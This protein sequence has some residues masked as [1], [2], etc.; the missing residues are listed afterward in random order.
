MKFNKIEDALKY[1][2][3]TTDLYLSGEECKK[4]YTPEIEKLTNLRSLHYFPKTESSILF[5]QRFKKLELES[6]HI[7]SVRVS[8]LMGMKIK[9]LEIQISPDEIL[10]LCNNFPE[11]E[12]LTL[13]VGTEFS[14]PKE[15]ENLTNLRSLSIRKGTLT[16]VPKTIGNLKKLKHLCL[17]SLNLKTLPLEFTEIPN[18]EEFS[19]RDSPQLMTLPKEIENWQNLKKITL[20]DLFKKKEKMNFEN[21][22]FR[23]EKGTELPPAL[24]GL[25]HLEEFKLMYCPVANLAPLAS[26][27]KLKRIKV[28]QAELND[29]RGVKELTNLES[30]ELGNSYHVNSIESLSELTNLKSLD[31]SDMKIKN[32]NPLKKLTRLEFLN[33][34]NCSFD[35][36]KSKV[37]QALLPLYAFEH[38]TEVEATNITL[39][40]WETRDKNDAQK[41]CLNSEDI[42]TILKDKEKSLRELED[43]LNSIVE[44]ESLFR[45]NRYDAEDRTLEIKILDSAVSSRIEDL[46]DE[47]LSKLV[48]VS[49]ADTS[50]GDSYEVTIIVIKEMIRRKSVEGQK[51][52][53]EAFMDCT[54]YYDPGHRYYGSTVQDQ[55]IDNLFSQ[56]ESEP[57][58]ILLLR[59]G[60]GLLSSDYGDNMFSLYPSLFSK[61]GDC[62]YEEAIIENLSFFIIEHHE[63]RYVLEGLNS[64][65]NEEIS[66]AS[67][68]AVEEIKQTLKLIN[69]DFQGNNTANIA[70]ECLYI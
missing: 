45:V 44:M 67:R 3:K 2:D 5:P 64:I 62:L 53:V 8:E 38:L 21:V 11:L 48:K 57:L 1:Y 30:L 46:S 33:V 56:F 36:S 35:K 23:N 52:V 51:I 50:M 20:Q 14:L 22:F 59:V 66:S 15:I 40:E 17:T 6:L 49:F 54:E 16:K 61:M 9:N 42:L 32:I 39:E 27:K 68:K 37:M 34:N 65:L 25:S 58:A 19:L 55:L 63:N 43:A 41:V 28:V 26:L 29:I 24:S 69:S 47:T 60:D 10:P 18:L 70:R 13:M 7:G 31:I 4:A 12:E